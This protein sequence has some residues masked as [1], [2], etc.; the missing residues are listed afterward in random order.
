[1][2]HKINQKG[3]SFNPDEINEEDEVEVVQEED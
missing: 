1:L 2:V 3:E